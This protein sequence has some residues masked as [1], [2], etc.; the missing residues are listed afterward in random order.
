MAVNTTTESATWKTNFG[1]RRM[2]VWRSPPALLG[3]SGNCGRNT[4]ISSAMTRQRPEINQKVPRQPS[5]SAA[6]VPK[7]MPNTN[8]AVMP[9]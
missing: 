1:S 8:A 6:S 5:A 2:T 3:A 9:R 4:H 7:G